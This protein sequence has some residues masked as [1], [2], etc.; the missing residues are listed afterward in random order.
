MSQKFWRGHRVKVADEMP[1][2]ML[3]F[4]GAGGE[5]IV[6]HSYRDQY[7]GGSCEQYCLLHLLPD[8]W[9]RSSWYPVD[10]LTLVSPDRDAGEAL[11]Q[12]YNGRAHG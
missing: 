3:H 2:W 11:L 7:G 10:L 9:K 4:Y 6:D 5:A 12:E 1:P 8:G